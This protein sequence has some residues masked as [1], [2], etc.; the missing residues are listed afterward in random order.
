MKNTL[1]LLSLVL[2]GIFTFAQAPQAFKYQAVARDLNGNPVINQEMSVKISIL[3]GS[4]DGTV[5]YSELHELP[6]NQMGLFDLEI[7]NPGLVLSG[8]FDT[9]DWGA[10]T[11]FLKMEMDENGG[12]NFQLMGISQLLSV[13]YALYSERT[14]NNDDADADP[15]NELQTIVKEGQTVTLSNGGGSFTDEITDAD[16]DPANELQT[17]TQN[18]LEV[19]LSQNGGTINVADNDNNPANELQ[20]VSKVGNVVSL[21]QDGGSFTDENTTYTAGSGLQLTGTTFS[22][23]APDQTVTVQGTGAATVTG[24]YP[25]FTVNAN[26]ADT[27]ATNELQTLAQNGLEVNLS[28]SGGT[29]NV[30]DNDNDPTNEIQYLSKIQNTL[31]LSGGGEVLV[32]V[33]S[34]TQPEID[35]LTPYNGLTVHN[36]TTNCINYFYLNNWFEACGTCTLKPTLAFAGNDTVIEGGETSLY[37]SAN[38]PEM[39]EGL[40]SVLSGDSGTFEDATNPV[41]LFTGLLEESYTLQWTIATSCDTTFDQVNITFYQWKCGSP[42]TDIRDGKNY[43]TVQIGLQCWMAENLNVGTRINRESV[44]TN[45][46]IIEKYC[47]DNNESFCTFYGGLY[48]WNEMMNYSTTSGVQ[49]ICPTGWHVPTDTEWTTLTTF[50]SSQT[51]YQCNSNAEYIAKALAA[52]NS[53]DISTDTCQPGSFF[54]TSN[55]TG[56]TAL[57]A[58]Y[59]SSSGYYFEDVGSYGIFWSSNRYQNTSA[60]TRNIINYRAT[61]DRSYSYGSM[62]LGGSVRCLKDN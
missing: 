17:L 49:G 24:T 15:T 5:V 56:F 35:A 46:S 20:Q 33:L 16:A 13:P 53:W 2:M 1:L 9:I 55:E 40:W 31:S 39:G 52:P 18:G 37:L 30:A 50:V 6:T 51:T 62:S 48:Q 57:A 45:N 10:T 22:N 14:A 42:I 21:S 61:V 59:R 12:L 36:A 58:G 47:I 8:S 44:Q 41:T 60:W 4:P 3:A 34:Y 27:S 23:T 25:N 19:S 7:G 43:N 26:P 32:G 38:T 11:Y 54:T 29:I 28:K